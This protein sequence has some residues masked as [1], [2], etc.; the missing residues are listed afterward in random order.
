MRNFFGLIDLRDIEKVIPSFHEVAFGESGTQY[1]QV[2][3]GSLSSGA[4]YYTNIFGTE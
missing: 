3:S 1:V 4:N 2:I